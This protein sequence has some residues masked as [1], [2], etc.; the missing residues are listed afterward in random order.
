M[1]TSL[2]NQG[3]ALKAPIV[4]QALCDQGQCTQ[5]DE[6]AVLIKADAHWVKNVLCD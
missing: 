4:N 6:N 3:W 2:C 5:F 1:F